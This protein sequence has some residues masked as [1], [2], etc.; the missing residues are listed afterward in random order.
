[1]DQMPP[2]VSRIS[3]RLHRL[4]GSIVTVLYP[5][6]GSGEV[7]MSTSIMLRGPPMGSKSPP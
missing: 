3:G 7:L 1:M 6:V 4:S 2:A 5:G